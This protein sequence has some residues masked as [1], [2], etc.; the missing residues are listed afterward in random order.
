MDAM[1]ESRRETRTQNAVVRA[2][3]Q[4]LVVAAAVAV[5]ALPVA[6]RFALLAMAV[7]FGWTQIGGV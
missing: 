7:V 1:I 2:T 3:L 5:L 6:P 4:L